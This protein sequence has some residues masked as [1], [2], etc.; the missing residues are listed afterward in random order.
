MNK[1]WLAA[2]I[3]FAASP[4]FAA[5][6]SLED[7]FWNFVADDDPQFATDVGLHTHDDKLQDWS[8]AAVER[9]IAKYKALQQRIEH[10]APG[11]TLPSKADLHLIDLYAQSALFHMID[12][13]QWQVSPS[14]YGNGAVGAVYGIIKRDFAP[15][16]QR[17]KLVVARENAIPSLVKAAKENL[18][19]VPRIS[20]ELAL[21]QLD[22]GIDFIGKDVVNAFK[23]IGD[24]T[25]QHELQQSTAI[26]TAA[27]RDYRDFLK[28]DLL[29]K[30][31]PDFAIGAE[32]FARKLAVDEG[33]DEP[34]DRILQRGEAE[35]ARLQQEFKATAAKIDPTRAPLDVQKS[36]QD[37]PP[38]ARILATVNGLLAGIRQFLVDKSIVTIPSP[39]MPIVQETPPFER[40]MTLASMDTPGAFEQAKQ[41]YYNV[42]LPDPKWTPQ[43]TESYL[44][45]AL[46]DY[47]IKMV[48]IHE[49]F[50][51]HYV[52][53]LWMPQMK[54]KTRKLWGCSSN[55]EGWAHYSE[56]MLLDEGYG[57][58]DAKLR[59][60]QIQEALLRAAR[61]VVGIRMHTKGMSLQEG[62]DFFQKQGFQ[63][64]KVADMEAKRGTQDPT[65]LVYTFGK[66]S[67]LKLRDDY[68]KKLGSAYTLRKFHDAF[69]AEGAVPLS[70][71]RRA[72]LEE[73]QP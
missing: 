17:L 58:G 32:R 13:P 42:T 10:P 73:V 21:Q 64:A 23:S 20:V 55:A 16:P 66:L 40:A 48:S 41:A 14:L 4:A 47:V 2:A 3:M 6:S 51:G 33:I 60:S 7:D 30:A 70:T 36:L 8:R 22:G 46:S 68:K 18:R 57:N 53:F 25:L 1:L 11:D 50:P 15:L 29:P 54:S 63:S 12:W 9:R 52:Q 44:S 49:A 38:A 65:Y 34:L 19:D 39:V 45:G 59:L 69:L 26:A 61:Y 72:L 24:A 43:Q 27:L 56:Q 67:I 62:I 28:K 35:L 37:H 31:K 5:P 71:V